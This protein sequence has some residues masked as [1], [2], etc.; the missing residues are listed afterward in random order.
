MQI[1]QIFATNHALH[2]CYCCCA[3][4]GKTDLMVRRRTSL[5]ATEWPHGAASAWTSR[6]APSTT[7]SRTTTAKRNWTRSLAATALG[8]TRT[9][10]GEKQKQN[11]KRKKRKNKCRPL[12]KYRTRQKKKRKEGRV[13]EALQI[14]FFGPKQGVQGSRGSYISI[15]LVVYIIDLVYIFFFF[16]ATRTRVL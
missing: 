4:S 5:V 13:S 15:Q 9:C 8:A 3:W 11:K 10:L 12:G 14:I 7:S 6:R 1:L 2:S 16:P